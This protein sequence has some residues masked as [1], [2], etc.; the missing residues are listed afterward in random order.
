V[1]LNSGRDERMREKRRV[2]VDMVEG[3]EGGGVSEN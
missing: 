2:V 3:D 1:E